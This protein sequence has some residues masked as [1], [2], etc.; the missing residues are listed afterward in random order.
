M[1]STTSLLSLSL[2]ACATTCAALE[3]TGVGPR[4][5]GMGGAGVACSDDYVAQFYNPAAFG[6]FGQGTG[7]QDK[8]ILGSDN[9]NLERKDWGV[10]ID[11]MAGA[12]IGGDLISYADAINDID[13]DKLQDIGKNGVIDPAAVK[14][15]IQIADLLGSIEPTKDTLTIDANV[16]MGIRIGHFGIGARGFSQV[17]ARF[18]SIDRKNLGIFGAGDGAIADRINTAING[19]NIPQAQANYTPKYFN[20]TQYNQLLS[21]LS[22]P[23]VNANAVNLAAQTLDTKASE[24]ELASE[25]SAAV[26]NA[27][28]GD[29]TANNPG[30]LAQAQNVSNVALE[31]NTTTVRLSGLGVGEIPISYGYAL[32]EHISFGATIKAMVGRVYV[33]EWVAYQDADDLENE[34]SNLSDNYEESY[35]F[36]VDA[37]VLFR[38]PYLQVGLNGRNL[39]AP[40]FKGPTVKGITYADE[41]IDPSL[42][43]GV[44]FVPFE[45]LTIAADVDLLETSTQNDGYNMQKVGG[46]I[47]WDAFRVLALRAGVSENIAESDVGL[48]YH[49]GVGLNLWALRVDLAAMMSKQTTTYDGE[50]VPREARASLAVATDW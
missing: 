16:G 18:V 25:T 12:R 2:L 13:V 14:Q 39:N 47:E 21:T 43:F 23:G 10:G 48:L 31:N 44:A 28:F 11:L 15:L 27:L 37:G 30:L 22:G 5:L 26:S 50:E 8:P 32:N 49:A 17:N 36:G 7:D 33:T 42:V 9:Q 6:F 19:A 45:T 4:A 40:S 41:T 3:E 35:N 20:Q 46:G 38:M 34:I 29:G 24:T 1:K